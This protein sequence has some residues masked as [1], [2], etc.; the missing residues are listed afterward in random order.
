MDYFWLGVVAA[1]FLVMGLFQDNTGV[2]I[3]FITIAAIL[4]GIAIHAS[5]NKNKE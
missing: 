5:R 1:V 3:L 4:G 2:M